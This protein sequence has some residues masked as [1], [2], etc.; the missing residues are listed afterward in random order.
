MLR[1]L[2]IIAV[3]LFVAAAGVAVFRSMRAAR[4]DWAGIAFAIGFVALAFYLG[5]ITGMSLL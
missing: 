5:H 4:I 3:L 1:L 2:F